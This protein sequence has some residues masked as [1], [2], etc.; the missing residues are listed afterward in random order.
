[1]ILNAELIQT[2]V[3]VAAG[4]IAVWEIV[5]LVFGQLYEHAKES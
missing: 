5:K 3:V 4:C 2:I 1:M